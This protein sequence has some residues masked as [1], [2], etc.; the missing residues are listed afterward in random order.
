MY[1]SKCLKG[2]GGNR[3]EGE[4]N[5]E[6]TYGSS[7]RGGGAVAILNLPEQQYL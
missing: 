7:G 1:T 5:R 6:I 4:S 3:R 2:G